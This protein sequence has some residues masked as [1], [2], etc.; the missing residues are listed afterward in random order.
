MS[1][2]ISDEIKRIKEAK[3]NIK[4]AINEKGGAITNELIDK[5]PDA[6][7]ALPS[8]DGGEDKWYEVVDGVL[9]NKGFRNGGTIII[10]GM[11][12]GKL[13][14]EVGYR[15]F[16]NA[17]RN[18]EYE[19]KG[20]PANLII[21][22]GIE[23]IRREAFRFANI[24]H[25]TLPNTLKTIERWG[26]A[27]LRSTGNLVL[28]NGLIKIG[29][30]AFD[31]SYIGGKLVIPDSVTS[32]GESAFNGCKIKEL[33]LSKSMTTIEGNAFRENEIAKLYIPDNIK[34]IKY[35]A[36]EYNYIGEVSIP[37]GCTYSRDAF[38]SYTKITVREV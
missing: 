25:I 5:Y 16:Y 30:D 15:L 32:I 13:V 14:K 12:D 2:N 31:S 23:V 4:A 21:E 20:T 36:F 7:R 8:G 22:D 11:I 37:S 27:D 29:D 6:I 10:P 34:T 35:S 33:V 18:S 9:M 24:G 26:F 19:N 17:G 38:Q 1:G 3:L 28:P